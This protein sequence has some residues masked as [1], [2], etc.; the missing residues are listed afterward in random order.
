MRP[1]RPN[2]HFGISRSIWPCCPVSREQAAASQRSGRLRRSKEKN[3]ENHWSVWNWSL[4]HI[5]PVCWIY[6]SCL[7][8]S[9]LQEKIWDC[10]HVTTV[11]LKTKSCLH[12]FFQIWLL[13]QVCSSK[14]I[15]ICNGLFR[16]CN[17]L[18]GTVLLFAHEILQ[19]LLYE[20]IFTKWTAPHCYHYMQTTATIVLL[21]IIRHHCDF[22]SSII[23]MF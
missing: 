6:Q 10:I 7:S 9:P 14:R 15:L 17:V 22:V 18:S 4:A 13:Y 8:S 12:C 23:C 19:S 1:L 3:F 5:V 11:S 21:E 20:S 16:Q 2:N